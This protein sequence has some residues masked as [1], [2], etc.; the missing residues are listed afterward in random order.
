MLYRKLVAVALVGTQCGHVLASFEKIA[1]YG[2]GSQVTDHNAIDLDQDALES[3]LGDYAFATAKTTYEDGGFSKNY[4]EIVIGGTSGASGGAGLA[5]AVKKSDKVVC[6]G[7]DGA[8]SE[9]KMYAKALA[10]ATTIK[11]A[12]ATSDVQAT[13]VKCRVRRAGALET[14]APSPGLQLTARIMICCLSLCD[15]AGPR[16]SCR[17]NWVLRQRPELRDHHRRC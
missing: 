11:V 1:G 4:A 8:T 15:D 10:D 6:T 17:E 13:Y 7:A 14:S 2:P 3:A 16:N 12:Y 9:G 5:T